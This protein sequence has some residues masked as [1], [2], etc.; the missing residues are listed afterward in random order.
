MAAERVVHLKSFITSFNQYTEE[1]FAFLKSYIV[2]PYHRDM[3]FASRIPEIGA[4]RAKA[5]LEN[6]YRLMPDNLTLYKIL[7][8]RDVRQTGTLSFDEFNTALQEF[9]MELSKPDLVA[10]CREME[11][12]TPGS[13][14]DQV[15]VKM[16]V[17]VRAC[18]RAG[19]RLLMVAASGRAR[20]GGVRRKTRQRNAGT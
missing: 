18:V 8:R 7:R 12:F 2:N 10:I 14:E 3:T 9:K 19:V 15:C 13:D 5:M 1:R 17:C 16:R 11:V 6:K 4:A 20:R